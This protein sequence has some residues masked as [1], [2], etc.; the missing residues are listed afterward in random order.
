MHA[1]FHFYPIEHDGTSLVLTINEDDVWLN[2]MSFK[3]IWKKM[4]QSGYLCQPLTTQE[5]LPS[6]S[7]DK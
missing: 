6:L 3:C 5:S 4:G 2:D 7:R 1:K